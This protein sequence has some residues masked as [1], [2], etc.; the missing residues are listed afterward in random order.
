V[1]ARGEDGG[2]I[3]G[4][5]L[6]PLISF[7]TA[8]DGSI[9]PVFDESGL[10]PILEK[11][12]KQVNR[13]ARDAGFK[14][15]SGRVVAIG[16]S[17]EGRTLNPAGMKA[18]ILSEIRARQAGAAPSRVA[19]VVKAVDPKLTTADAKAFAGKMRP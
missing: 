17:H 12:G 14:L 15:V 10:D 18:T 4:R 19:A 11:L 8:A 6:A 7:S 2:T 5:S 3:A 9:S 13:P 16:T 1:A